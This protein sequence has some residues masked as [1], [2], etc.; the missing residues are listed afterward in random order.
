YARAANSVVAEA[1]ARV[2][3]SIPEGAPARILEVGGGTAATTESVIARL[4]RGRFEYLFTDLSPQLVA[5]ARQKFTGRPELRYRV[6]DAERSPRVERLAPRQFDVVLAANVVHATRDLAAT[7]ANLDALLAPGGMLVLLEAVRA[8]TWADLIFGLLEEWWRFTDTELRGSHPLLPAQSWRDLLERCG[9]DPVALLPR[10]ETGEDLLH[11][12]AVLVGR[13]RGRSAAQRPLPAGRWLVVGEGAPEAPALESLLGARGVSVQGVASEPADNVLF[14]ASPL[15]D[16]EAPVAAARHCKSALDVVQRMIGAALPSPPRLWVVTSGAQPVTPA[17]PP[18]DPAQA[19][20]WGLGRVI[21]LEHPEL[22]GGL[23][24]LDPTGAPEEN[25]RALAGHILEAD[26]ESQAAIRA[27]ARWVAR[28]AR[29]GEEPGARLQFRADATYLVTGGLGGLGIEVARW[30]AR[31]GAGHIVLAG[32]RAPEGRS[33]DA[34]RDLKRAGADVVIRRLDVS[35]AEEVEAVLSEIRASLPPLCGVLHCPG[36]LDDGVLASA[37]WSRFA[38]VFAPKVDGSWNLH[39]AT[40][41]DPLDFFVLFS[42]IAGLMGSPGQGNHAAANAFLDALADARRSRG[43]PGLSVGW[44]GWGETGAAVKVGTDV[45]RRLES[46][47]FRLMSPR[48]ALAA[49]DH[50]LARGRRYLAVVSLDWETIARAGAGAAPPAFLGEVLEN[51]RCAREDGPEAAGTGPVETFLAAPASERTGVLERYL[52]RLLRRVTGTEVAP[53]ADF[54]ATGFDSLMVI[55]VVQA[56]KRDLAL[57]IYPR[58]I[59]EHPTVAALAAH[60]AAELLRLGG[61]APE[62]AVETEAALPAAPAAARR[63]RSRPTGPRVPGPVFVLSSPRSGSTLLRVMLAG[64]PDL[65]SPPELHLLSYDDLRAWHEGLDGSFLEEGLQRA[66]MELENLDAAASRARL[67][68]LIEANPTTAEVYE[69]LRELARPRRLVDKSPTYALAA[70]TLRRSEEL[71]E[72]ARYVH[73]VRHPYAVLE[74]FV[75]MRMDQ[76]VGAGGGDRY[77]LAEQTWAASN[78]NMLEFR[79]SGDPARHHLVRYEELVT[80]PDRVMGGVCDFLGVPFS[81][82]LLRPYDPGRMTDG[83]HPWSMPID[84]PNF[85]SRNRIEPALAEAW[86]SVELPAPLRASTADV[87]LELGYALPR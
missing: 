14:L 4:P 54:V 71:F 86:R 57:V 58:E 78:R 8:S 51:T 79:R 87:A 69:L 63:S 48:G 77:E 33:A 11:G 22:W 84:D 18:V 65:F 5:R 10:P 59:Y 29:A 32:R 31:G 7:V 42:S 53:A 46:R 41:S 23:V 16:V 13:S 36:V 26:R 68:G 81:E 39:R 75:R 82:E 50:A 73:L 61:Q 30:L 6:L 62:R 83:V 35:Q 85:R 66:L 67:D 43:L 2:I 40:R 15:Q 64:H 34:V 9:L 27:G 24:D 56:L 38:R 20:L 45:A 44:G 47:G 37:D 70:E 49:L 19:A 21:G 3:E 25:A 74:S 76:V 60:L 55:E 52:A 28:L 80:M 1:V 17:D 12:Q 72:G